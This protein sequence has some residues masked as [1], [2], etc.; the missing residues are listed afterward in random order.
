MEPID[1]GKRRRLDQICYGSAALDV[2]L[3]SSLGLAP[4]ASAKKRDVS[5]EEALK[6][7]KD[8]V[9][10]TLTDSPVRPVQGRV[11]RLVTARGQTP[12]IG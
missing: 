1:P 5:P 8:G 2:S 3:A 7:R 10:K 4:A 12:I 9:A 11:R 6:G